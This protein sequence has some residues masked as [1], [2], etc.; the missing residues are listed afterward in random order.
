MF[1]KNLSL[2]I[3]MCAAVSSASAMDLECRSRYFNGD[4]MK[5]V[6]SATSFSEDHLNGLFL[7]IDND[8]VR[9]IKAV[10]GT[11]YAGRKYK[12]MMVY[13]L[14][15]SSGQR[16]GWDCVSLSLLLPIGWSE[17]GRFDGYIIEKA[18]DGGSYNKVLCGTTE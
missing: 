14:K 18:S 16:S 9:K 2:L 13:D 5:V 15:M 17:M 7:V 10:K 8:L 12:N 4:S 3:L 1:F 11:E 6:L